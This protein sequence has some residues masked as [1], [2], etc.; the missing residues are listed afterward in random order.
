VTRFWARW[1]AVC[2]LVVQLSPA[3]AVTQ[4]DAWQLQM[5]RAMTAHRAGDFTE[6]ESRLRDALRL[7]ED[8]GPQDDRLAETLLALAT[9]YY[10][11]ADYAAAQVPLERAAEIFEATA[12]PESTKFATLLNA[13]ALVH[14]HQSQPEAARPLYRR[15]LAIFEAELGPEAEKVQ[16]SHRRCRPTRWSC[17]IPTVRRRPTNSTPAPKQSWIEPQEPTETTAAARRAIVAG[18]R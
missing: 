7:A 8:F 16:R 5:S 4:E 11:R 17:A 6:A 14:G 1:A 12:G 15:A 2:L 13:L 9:V 10:D 3:H 18:W